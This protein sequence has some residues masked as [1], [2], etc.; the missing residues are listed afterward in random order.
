MSQLMIFLDPCSAPSRLA[1]PAL[2]GFCHSLNVIAHWYPFRAP[3]ERRPPREND[4]DVRQRH[5]RI[6]Q[7]YRDHDQARYAQWLS[8]SLE[9]PLSAQDRDLIDYAILRTGTTA[10]C[11]HFLTALTER[12][13]GPDK[14][15]IN[16]AELAELSGITDLATTFAEHGPVHLAKA[17]K[18]IEPLGIFDA[19]A[20]LVEGELFIGRQHLPAIRHLLTQG[21]PFSPQ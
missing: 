20:C 2:I 14:R 5:Q 8:L 10:E 7:E 4:A 17:Q 9:R 1:L 13:W 3:P 11:P 12:L 18:E 16:A 19:P 21:D 6:R 15:A